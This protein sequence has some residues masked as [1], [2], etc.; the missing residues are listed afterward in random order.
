[1]PLHLAVLLIP[2]LTIWRIRNRFMNDP[3]RK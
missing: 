3:K 2:A 1:M